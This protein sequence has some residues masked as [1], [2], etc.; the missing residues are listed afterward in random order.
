M[1]SPRTFALGWRARWWTAVIFAIFTSTLAAKCLTGWP[2][3]VE[4]ARR[5][6]VGPVSEG[7][8]RRARFDGIAVHRE[9][10]AR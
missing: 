4:H 3:V 2:P 5:S 6:E 7:Q 1:I 9:E 10:F 8:T